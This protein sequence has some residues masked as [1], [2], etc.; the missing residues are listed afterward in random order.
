MRTLR[1]VEVLKGGGGGNHT[2]DSSQVSPAITK[3][4]Y[5]VLQDSH[6]S[7]TVLSRLIEAI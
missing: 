7:P 4:P 1:L 5:A 2:A 3:K 6:L